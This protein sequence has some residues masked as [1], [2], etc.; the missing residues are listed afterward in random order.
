MD[1]ESL[2]AVYFIGLFFA[3]VLRLPHRI[4]RYRYRQLWKEAKQ[5][6]RQTEWIVLPFVLLGIWILPSIY[7]FSSCLN[8]FDYSLPDGLTVVALL[9]FGLSLIIRLIAQQTLS[10]SW[11]FTLETSEDHELICHG[12]YSITRHPIYVSLIFWA[13][14][15]PVLLQNYAA[16]FGGAAAV[17]LIWLIRVPREEQLLI[18]RFGDQYRNYMSQTGRLFTRRRSA[19]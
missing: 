7:A 11:S 18:E 13:I 17:V 4:N 8:S 14:T 16:G 9:L 6:T 19:D 10:R 5:R 1:K 12:I 2:V 15:Q 3:E